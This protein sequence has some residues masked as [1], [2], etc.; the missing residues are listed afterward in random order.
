MEYIYSKRHPT[1]GGFSTGGW[2]LP[3]QG[4]HL[5]W[6]R[7]HQL[8]PG[9]LAQPLARLLGQGQES[10]FHK[11]RDVPLLQ[12]QPCHHQT[13]TQILWDAMSFIIKRPEQAVGPGSHL[14]VTGGLSSPGGQ[15]LSKI[16]L[17]GKATQPICL[18]CLSIASAS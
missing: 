9:L 5:W 17:H 1:L 3:G 8:Q 6:S 4:D 13:F 12:A 10:W 15:L 16:L 14:C 2:Q 11:A 18:G 7:S